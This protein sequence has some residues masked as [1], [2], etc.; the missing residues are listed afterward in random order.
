VANRTRSRSFGFCILAG[1]F[2]VLV[3][4]A[5]LEIIAAPATPGAGAE[6]PPDPTRHWAFLSPTAVT[7]PAVQR[8]RWLATPVDAFILARLE[9][10]GLKPSARADKATLLRRVTFDLIGLPPTPAELDAF[11]ADPAPGAFER[12]VDRLLASPHYGERWGRHWLD[13]ARYADSNGQDENK[14]MAHAWRYRDYVIAAFNQDKPFD[15]FI[16]EQLAGDL[17][18]PSTDERLNIERRTATGFLVLGPKMLAEQDKPKLIMDVIDEQIDV[19]SRAFLGLTV[20]CSRCHDHKFDPIPARDYYALAGIFKSTKTMGDLA[21]VSKWNERPAAT[22]DEIS[23]HEEFV[24]RTNEVAARLATARQDAMGELRSRWRAQAADYL[25]AALAVVHGNKSQP[26]PGLEPAILQRWTEH[27]ARARTNGLSAPSPLAAFLPLNDPSQDRPGE[28][29]AIVTNLSSAKLPPTAPRF[30]DGRCGPALKCAGH[31]Y[32]ETAHAPELEPVHLTVEGWVYLEE[33]AKDGDSRRWLVNKNANEWEQGHYALVL[34]GRRPG[35]Y[36][37]IGGGRENAFAVWSDGPPITLKTWTHLAFTY[38]GRDLRLYVDGKSAGRTVI[39]RARV[40]GQGTFQ[41]G[42]RQDGYNYFAGGLDEIILYARALSPEEILRRSQKPEDAA[43]GSVLRRWSFDPAT[44]EE[45]R[46]ATHA[47]LQELLFAPGGLLAPPSSPSEAQHYFA[48]DHAATVR[49]WELAQ[50]TLQ[51]NAPPTPPVAMAVEDTKG[52]DLPVYLRGS[53]LTPGKEKVPR[54]FVPVLSRAVPPP[55]IPAGNSGRLELAEWLTHPT[56]PLTARVIVNRIWQ[57]HF[58]EGLVRTP[59]NFG[60]RG[61]KP[62][63]PEL[64]DWLA[65]EFI[66]LDWSVKKLH[67]LLVLSSTYQMAAAFNQK[68]SLVD[69]D[70]RLLWRMNRR[71]LDAEPLRDALLA[72]AGQLDRTMGGSLVAWPNAE[73]T[74]EDAVSATSRRRAVYLPVV[75]DRVYDVFTIFDF[76]NPSVGVSQRTPTVVAHQALFFLNSPFVKEQARFLADAVLAETPAD[77]NA[78]LVSAYRRALGR[79]PTD[80]E[81]Q[82]GLRFIRAMAQPVQVKDVPTNSS[83]D[84]EATRQAWA[85]FCQALFASNEFLYVN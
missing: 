41:L 27:L 11:L 30:Q 72:V 55:S 21:F 39:G 23:R 26:T 38:D 1:C 71:R 82:Q 36:L 69:P 5:R 76:A 35:A 29:A 46:A 54:G 37:N 64:L 34:D 74:P 22:R 42:R 84:A 48:P 4:P 9:A 50:A 47:S 7:L 61:E 16:R 80:N 2:A 13:V 85:A 66:R 25:Q 63:H 17:L 60:V 15:Q 81:I 75:R 57:A 52:I 14:V 53:H 58:G 49:R 31:N 43:T 78:R 70:N 28:F 40:P 10:A 67:R 45:K 32:L 79:R 56:H 62:T 18:P 8:K 19:V 24:A 33:P 59:D 83:A 73:Y 6:A 12:V 77:D 20:S 68:S 65:R 51:S 3:L 44:A